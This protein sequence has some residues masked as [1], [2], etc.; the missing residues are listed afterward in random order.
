MR[1]DEER[2][3][4]AAGITRVVPAWVALLTVGAAGCTGDPGDGVARRD[5]REHGV[6]C[7]DGRYTWAGVRHRTELTALGEPVT[8]PKGTDSY[9][10]RLRP[11][12]PGTV[13]RPAVTGAPRGM[14]AARELCPAGSR[15]ATAARAAAQRP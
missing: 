7:T 13:H 15:A 6:T 3:S 2:H 8:F 9:E 4:R 10:T 12:E 5:D 14:S 11:V 1:R